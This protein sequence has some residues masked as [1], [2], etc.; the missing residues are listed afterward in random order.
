MCEYVCIKYPRASCRRLWLKCEQRI[1]DNF[2]A[3]S[4]VRY[5]CIAFWFMHSDRE[6]LAKM[7]HT[8]IGK[9]ISHKIKGQSMNSLKTTNKTEWSVTGNEKWAIFFLT[10]LTMLAFAAN[11]LLTRMAFQKTTID[12]ASFTALR[13]LSGAVTLFII[14]V[15]R[16]EKVKFSKTY[17]VSAV[18]LFVYATAFSFAYRNI[19]TGAGALVLFAS[20]QI[21]MISYGIYKGERA[22]ILGMLLALGGLAVFLAPGASAPPLGAASLMALAG[23]AWG[24]FSLLGKNGESPIAVTASSFLMAVPF[25]LILILLPTQMSTI[26]YLGATYALLSGSL[27]S[28]VGYALWYSV[29][30]RMAA[31]TAGAVQ[32]SVPLLSAVLGA[33]IL[34]EVITVKGFVS[35]LIVLIGIAMVTLTAKKK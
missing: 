13:I 12:P 9:Q 1:P 18:A 26:D 6:R 8:N 32:L 34:D 14:L 19:S 22:S 23:F 10:C 35:A 17:F 27:A 11:S 24:F 20:A 25:S 3:A 4:S 15:I 28:G 5:F 33:L 29:R 30:V 16:K 21:L 2:T 7:H 31:I